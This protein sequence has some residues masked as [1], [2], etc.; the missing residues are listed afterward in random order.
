MLGLFRSFSVISASFV[1]TGST[2]RR[3]GWY[4]GRRG[5]NISHGAS[6]HF[7]LDP[8]MLHNVPWIR[9]TNSRKMCRTSM[10]DIRTA[11]KMFEYN[12]TYS[13]YRGTQ[14]PLDTVFTS[15]L[16]LSS[17]LSSTCPVGRAPLMKL[18]VSTMYT[19]IS[20]SKLLTKIKCI[21]LSSHVTKPAMIPTSLL[22]NC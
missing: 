15:V 6:L 19:I 4:L 18:C 21:F 8:T 20:L 5:Y 10:G 1:V 22:N 13:S 2:T 3:R 9:N 12:S 7:P 16:L 11:Y 14:I 17:L